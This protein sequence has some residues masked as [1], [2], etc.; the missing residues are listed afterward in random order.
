MVN[1]ISLGIGGVSEIEMKTL[2]EL[3]LA[4]EILRD[5][6]KFS[7]RCHE[8]VHSLLDF[9]DGNYNLEYAEIPNLK[10]PKFFEL[11]R[12]SFE[13]SCIISL[14]NVYRGDKRIYCA[15]PSLLKQIKNL[16]PNDVVD[17]CDTPLDDLNMS[18][19][20]NLQ[21]HDCGKISTLNQLCEAVGD[22]NSKV[23]KLVNLR[24][25]FLA[26]LQFKAHK[27]CRKPD[28]Y[29]Q[30]LADFRNLINLAISII[31]YIRNVY[32]KIET[33]NSFFWGDGSYRRDVNIVRQLCAATEAN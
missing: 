13:R 24:S 11:C 29:A 4:T 21:E 17:F 25:N 15:L 14:I 22:K 2:D 32:L 19:V 6:L 28:M 8:A 26:H 7:L 1:L 33:D 9:K 10:A 20:A 23:I 18:M 3:K 30:D 12:D 27:N 16:H 31:I 5:E